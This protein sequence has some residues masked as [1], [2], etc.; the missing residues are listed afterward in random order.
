M[1]EKAPPWAFF[2]KQANIADLVILTPFAIPILADQYLVLWRLISEIVSPDRPLGKI[3]PDATLFVNLAGAFA[4]LAVLLRMRLANVEAAQITGIFKLCAVTIFAVA[5]LR[6]SSLVFAVPL[7]ADL[8]M[9]SLLLV[10]S[11]KF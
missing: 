11:K 5:L 8:V 10:S 9:G 4:V 2:F 7:I 3:G 1:T 6:G